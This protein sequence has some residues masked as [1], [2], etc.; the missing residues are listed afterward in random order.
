MKADVNQ[1]RSLLELAE[2]DAELSRIAHRAANLPE[3]QQYDQIQAEHRSA[4]DRLAAVGIALEDIDA[5]V[6]R[7]ETEIDGVRQREDRDRKLLDSG[8]INPKQLEELQHEL[9]TLE[10]RQASLEDS[11]L[12]VMERREQ[13]ATEQVDALAKVD[14]LQHDLAA[15]Q[16]AR[17][18]ALADIDQV[19]GQRAVRRDELVAGLDAELVVLY[20][21]QRAASGVGAGRLQGRRCG[22][23]RIELDRGEI[24]RIT[25]ASED[26]VLQCSECRAILLRVS[27]PGQ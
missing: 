7:F 6:S 20:E 22:A 8:T 1:Q 14:G 11:L 23:C 2:L 10:R 12:E 18:S 17:D 25:A 3:Q 24:A 27:G 16:Q 21:R 19:R 9:G 4:N 15:A 13:L 26:E 5:Q